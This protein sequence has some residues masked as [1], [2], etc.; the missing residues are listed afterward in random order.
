MDNLDLKGIKKFKSIILEEEAL[1][2]IFNKS[3]IITVIK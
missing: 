3:R 1:E 2:A